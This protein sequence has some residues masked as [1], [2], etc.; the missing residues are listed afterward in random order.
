[1]AKKHKNKAVGSKNFW[2]KNKVLVL[3]PTNVGII[4]DTCNIS[5]KKI[6]ASF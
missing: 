6:F 4:F 5:L 3:F 1:M 2:H